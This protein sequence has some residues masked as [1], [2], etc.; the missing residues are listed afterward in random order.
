MYSQQMPY[1]AEKFK[2][3]HSFASS[4]LIDILPEDKVD[5]AVIYQESFESIILENKNGKLVKKILPNESQVSPIKSSIVMDV[6]QDGIKDIIVVGNHYGVEVEQLDMMRFGA[7][8]LG[9][10]DG[11]YK[12]IPPSKSGFYSLNSRDISI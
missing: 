4:K 11:N 1:V 3:F 9:E 6:N 5:D 12:F 8:L 10:K 2:D 7:V